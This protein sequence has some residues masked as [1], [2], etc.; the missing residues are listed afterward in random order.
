MKC[1]YGVFLLLIS[2]NLNA[3]DLTVKNLNQGSC[4]VSEQDGVRVADFNNDSSFFLEAELIQGVVS[5]FTG[6]E[7]PK[8]LETFIHCS[9]S[10]A[11]VVMNFS[12]KDKKFCLWTKYQNRELELVSLGRSESISGECD[13]ITLA[14]VS[15]KKFSKIANDEIRQLLDS[16]VF[17]GSVKDYSVQGEWWSVQGNETFQFKEELLKED[18]MQSGFFESFEFDHLRHHQ[19]EFLRINDLSL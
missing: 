19:G 2:Y 9:G 12:D 6:G 3:T 1:I 13:G 14:K 5:N 7:R 11:S 15:F 10:G 18:L 17:D 8:T 4:W 16:K